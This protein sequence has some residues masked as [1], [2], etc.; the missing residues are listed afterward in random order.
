[1]VL[2]KFYHIYTSHDIKSVNPVHYRRIF[3]AG[4]IAAGVH[5]ALSEVQSYNPDTDSW[6]VINLYLTYFVHYTVYRGVGV[7]CHRFFM[8]SVIIFSP[9]NNTCVLESSQC[10]MVM[11]SHF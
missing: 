10:T 9:I 4:G 6:E 1:M 11:L 7:Y 3:I 8:F 5:S 2:T